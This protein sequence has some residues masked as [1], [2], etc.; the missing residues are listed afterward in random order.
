MNL[1]KLRSK[2]TEFIYESFRILPEQG[3][4]KVTFDFLLTPDIKFKPSVI[5]PNIS[6]QR[7][8]EIGP[9]VLENL[10]FNLGIVE[11][12]SY[13]K[14]ACPAEILIKAGF[15]G[16][17]QKAWWKNLL[18]KGLGEFFYTNKIDFTK[19]DLVEFVIPSEVQNDRGRIQDDKIKYEGALQN[20]DLILVGG[21][22]DSAVTLD[23]MKKSGYK[24]LMLNPTQA[25]IEI[26][27]IAG[28][29]DPIIIQ[30]TIDPKLLQLN[31][32]S[33]LNGH[34]PFSAY[35]AFLATLAAVLYN[36]KNIIVSN[37]ASSNE[38]NVSW[39]GQ[40]INHQYSKTFEFENL[41]RE[42]SKKYLANT[43]YFS[44]LRS[45]TE[46][47][48]S[49]IFAGMSQYH[50]AFR[51]CNRGMKENIWCGKCP[52]CVSTYL[53]LFPF[54]GSKTAEI[55]GKNLLEDESLVPIIQGLMRENDV[56]KPFECV[57]SVEEVKV[58]IFLGLEKAGAEVPKV[59]QAVSNQALDKREI[60]KNW[61]EQNNLS[62]EYAEILRSVI[63]GD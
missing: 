35:L 40:E 1:D 16:G 56:V 45:L 23:I 55:F 30:R 7:L 36:Y 34:T 20:R 37:E 49:Q 39:M 38:G 26:A 12:L 43:N 11:L 9:K 48:I 61:N 50:Q 63:A 31:Q 58:A 10:V 41:F 3:N 4:L 53:T 42:Y 21:G 32:A 46:L 44:F 62:E 27:K 15:L 14:A 18:I 25:A 29:E 52:K 57:A 17:E 47:Q 19:K 6:Q 59:L 5:F 54:L 2:H 28:S 22:K 13:W 33:Y 8:E 24:S 60:L 51:S